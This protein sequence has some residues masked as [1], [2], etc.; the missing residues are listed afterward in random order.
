MT[1]PNDRREYWNERYATQ[2]L[3]WGVGANR[4][5]AAELSG[6]SPRR[7]LDL[8]CGQGRNAI[9]LAQQ[10]HTVT[11]VDVSDVAI[12]H[13]RRLA[14]EAGVDVEFVAHDLATWQPEPAAYDLV[15]LSYLQLPAAT[16]RIVHA[17]AVT[18]V[19]PGGRILLIAHH[20]DNLERG[21]GGPQSLDVLFDEAQLADDFAELELVR[22]EVVLRPVDKDGMSGEAI[23]ILFIAEKSA[24]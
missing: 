4:F 7:A 2:G 1:S 5:V 11:G 19:A 6:L 8:G 23:D 21:I 17:S 10:G 15:V 13:A 18:A 20:R 9:W 16:R 12:D 3:V 14:A 22:N 24:G